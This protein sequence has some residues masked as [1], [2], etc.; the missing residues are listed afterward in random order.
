MSVEGLFSLRSSILNKV[1]SSDIDTTTGVV[2][3][4][5]QQARVFIYSE[6]GSDLVTTL[7]G[8]ATNENP[9]TD[10]EISKMTAINLEVNLVNASLLRRLPVATMTE[11]D[12]SRE[13]FNDDALSR[14][15]FALAKHL[16]WLDEQI[17]NALKMLLNLKPSTDNNERK[18]RWGLI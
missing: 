11:N 2:D 3:T 17:E 13:L 8:Y 5:L 16:D 1:R 18:P 12:D 9:T 14:E 10:E 15:A 7:V 4:S 6:L